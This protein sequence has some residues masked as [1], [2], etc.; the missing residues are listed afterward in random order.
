MKRSKSIKLVV[1]ASSAAALAGCSDEPQIEGTV[2]KDE[3]HCVSLNVLSADECK[4]VMTKGWEIHQKSGPRYSSAS[5][6][7]SEHSDNTCYKQEENSRAY[8]TPLPAGYFLAAAAVN[9]AT[10]SSVRPIY[11]DKKGRGYYTSGGYFVSR[12]SGQSWST[13]DKAIKTTPKPAKLQTRTSV[14]SRKGFGGRS[15]FSFGG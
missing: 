15:S 3:N 13:S 9:A 12:H 14:A 7:N 2:Y 4:T 5:L 6:C 8:Y 11:S 1:M 10:Q